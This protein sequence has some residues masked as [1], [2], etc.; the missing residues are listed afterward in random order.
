MEIDKTKCVG[1]GNCHPV[2]PMEAISLDTDGKSIVNQDKCVECSTCYRLLRNE[3]YP[4]FLVRVI[5]GILGVFHLQYL[6]APDVC[7]TGALTPPELEYPRSLRAAFSDPTVVHAGTGVG[8][9]G[10]EEIKTND[11]TGRL[12]TGDAG[13]VIELGRPGTGAYFRDVEKVAMALSPLEPHFESFNPVTQL[14]TD[15]KT[16]KIRD[17]VLDEKVLSAIIE[18]K[19]KLERIPEYLQVLE[20][21]Q[22]ELDTVFSVGVASKCLPD[23]SVPHQQWVKD[24]GY[25]LS[26]NGKTNLGLGRPL[27]KEESA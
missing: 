22:D 1:C 6:A 25:T 3:G 13:I 9:R 17:E 18:V 7:P 8:G 11:I 21:V 2:C 12:R 20:E 23:G 5:R 16:G 15:T 24:A 26:V 14:M 10:T 27:F 19:T 4:P